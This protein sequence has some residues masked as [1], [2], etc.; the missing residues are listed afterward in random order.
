MTRRGRSRGNP[1]SLRPGIHSDRTGDLYFECIARIAGVGTTVFVAML[2]REGHNQVFGIAGIPLSPPRT[3]V[4]DGLIAYSNSSSITHVQRPVA[5][6]ELRGHKTGSQGAEV[7]NPVRV[8]VK[9]VSSSARVVLWWAVVAK[10]PFRS[11]ALVGEG[12][13]AGN[14]YLRTSPAFA[15]TFEHLLSCHSPTAAALYRSGFHCGNIVSGCRYGALADLGRRRCQGL[16]LL[17]LSMEI[18]CPHAA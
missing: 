14:S 17:Q 3:I 18:P 13:R 11:L 16:G 8:N 15:C 5:Q 9:Q 10:S 6:A 4:V 12:K 7:P 2:L 1:G